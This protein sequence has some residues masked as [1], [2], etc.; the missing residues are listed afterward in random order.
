MNKMDNNLSIGVVVLNLDNS[1]TNYAISAYDPLQGITTEAKMIETANPGREYQKAV[2]TYTK[3]D[4][5][6]RMLD[7]YEGEFDFLPNAWDVFNFFLRELGVI[8]WQEKKIFVNFDSYEKI[9]EISEA[10]RQ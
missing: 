9:D 7:E 6:G 4:S 5:R 2:V 3:R 10:R 1:T 8:C